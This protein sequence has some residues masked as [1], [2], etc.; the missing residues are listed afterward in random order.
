MFPKHNIWAK[1]LKSFLR[2]AK[3]YLLLLLLQPH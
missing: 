2:C 1:Y 3:Y